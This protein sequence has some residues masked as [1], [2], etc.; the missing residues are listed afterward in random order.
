MVVLLSVAQCALFNAFFGS[1]VDD[2][3]VHIYARQMHI[4][5]GDFTGCDYALNFY[6]ANFAIAAAGL[7]LRAVKLKRRL[8]LWSAISALTKAISGVNERSIT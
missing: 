6:D 3:A 8:P 1:G 4:I 5:G 2:D 7:K